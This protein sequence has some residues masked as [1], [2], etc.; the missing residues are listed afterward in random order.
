M[1][2]QPR[3]AA[4]EGEGTAQ[5]APIADGHQFGQSI[6]VGFFQDVDGIAAFGRRFP[7]GVALARHGLAQRLAR[8][9]T[10]VPREKWSAELCG[11]IVL[12]SPLLML[13]GFRHVT[14]LRFAASRSGQVVQKFVAWVRDSM[15]PES[16]LRLEAVLQQDARRVVGALA[17]AAD[18]V[19]LAVARQLAQAR[20][21]LTQRDV[22]R[23][24]HAL[25]R[26]LHRLAHV[27]QEALVGRIPVA[28]RH[29]AAQ[30]VGR[31]HPR[32][33]DRVLRA[34]ELRRVA[35]LGLLE[36]VDRRAHLD[37]HGERADALVHVRPRR[38]PAR[39]AAGRRTCGRSPSSRSASRPGSSPRANSGRG[40][41]SRSPCRRAASASS[42]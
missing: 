29:V 11:R 37:R 23:A 17:R 1:S 31:D 20:A 34:A 18:D 41:S 13:S 32:E 27:E 15:P 19:D 9:Q 35:E 42:R 4:Q 36:V 21:Q 26:E 2:H 22:D 28:E 40:R 12:G 25:H 8:R 16:V 14:S 38:A 3:R 10:L 30:D 6:P 39:R 5:H 24:R 33:V 7:G